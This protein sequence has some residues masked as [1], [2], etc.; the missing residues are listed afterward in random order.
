MNVNDILEEK[1]EALDK[2]FERWYKKENLESR[3][4]VA[5]KQGYTGITLSVSELNDV[6]TKRRLNN[7][8]VINKLK[9]ELIGFDIN[10]EEKTGDRMFINSKIGTWYR[11]TISISWRGK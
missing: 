1:E 5:A 7:P 6:Y 3:I 4:K 9:K 10:Y 2:W 11:K 8:E